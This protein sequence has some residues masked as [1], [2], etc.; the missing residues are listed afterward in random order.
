MDNSLIFYVAIIALSTLITILAVLNTTNIKRIIVIF[1]FLLI[2]FLSIFA[3]FS[4]S[5]HP[6]RNNIITYLLYNNY[7][8]AK[9]VYYKLEE[10]KAIY[11]LLRL[12]KLRYS[13]YI[14]IPW[15]NNTAKKLQEAN[16]GENGADASEADEGK[17]KGM[18]LEGVE[19][20]EIR[21]DNFKHDRNFVRPNPPKNRIQQQRIN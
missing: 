8:K 14:Q 13:L 12:E 15:D 18:L 19:G 7:N 21:P 9:V 5:G 17:L 6:T 1:S 11:L 10:N 2:L 20:L 3:I 4:L 16:Q